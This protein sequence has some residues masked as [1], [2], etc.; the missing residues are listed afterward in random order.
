MSAL[1]KERLEDLA[2]KKL[3]GT[4]TQEE[5][6]LLDEWLSAPTPE[7][8]LWYGSEE[9]FVLKM[10]LLKRI[11]TEADIEE[12]QIK[13]TIPPLRRRLY[14]WLSAAAVLL[15]MMGAVVWFG[16][17]FNRTKTAQPVA[18]TDI[19]PGSVGAILTLSDGTTVLLDSIQDGVVASQSGARAM[20]GNGKLFYQLQKNASAEPVYNTI[21]TPKARQIQLALSDGTKVWLNA[22]S[23]IRYPVVFNKK[24]RYVEVSGEVYFEVT[25]NTRS[26]FRV[27]V[28]GRETVEVLGTS[29]NINAY[30]N[31][32]VIRTTLL[33]G[34]VKVKGV[35][36]EGILKPGEQSVSETGEGKKGFRIRAGIDVHKVVAWK[37]GA[38]DFDGASLEEIMRQLERWYDIKVIYEGK[39]PGMR[40]GGR[41]D[42]NT[43]LA[44]LLKILKDAEVN[45]R[46]EGR[47]LIVTN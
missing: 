33:E 13:N 18:G 27:S 30:E 39:V 2:T 16:Q 21:T 28:A 45:F 5:Q 43:S 9:E 36:G 37:E 34:S 32:S 6:F 47:T 19:A 23:S 1:T 7:Q 11:H 46:I 31:E 44:S 17:H 35:A 24:E 12:T 3:N 10:R 4:I 29:F 38:F 40:F 42:R 20:F 15:V 8:N 25:K 22:G 26:P 41:L 14:Q